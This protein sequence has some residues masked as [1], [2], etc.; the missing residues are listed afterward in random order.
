MKQ[1]NIRQYLNKNLGLLELFIC[2]CSISAYAI[3]KII[4]SNQIY[5]TI[6]VIVLIVSFI[7]YLIKRF[8]FAKKLDD[9]CEEIS[10]MFFNIKRIEIEDEIIFEFLSENYI[11]D[12]TF[13]NKKAIKSDDGK[14]RTSV[15]ESSAL[16]F[17]KEKGYIYQQKKSLLT[18]ECKLIERKFTPSEIGTVSIEQ[19]GN[20]YCV[21]INISKDEFCFNCS[22]PEKAKELVKK[23]K[24]V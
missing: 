18:N 3:C 8:T 12:N 21:N 13:R 17:T 1:S 4:N 2:T 14:W 23:I 7:L 11:Y 15:Y 9:Y 19:N 22:T 6:W 10:K 24:S 5:S 20:N 16:F